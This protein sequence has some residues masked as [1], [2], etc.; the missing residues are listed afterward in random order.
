ML[1][2]ALISG[3]VILS[4]LVATMNIVV[5]A[6]TT[7]TDDT[8]DVVIE[9]EPATGKDYIDIKQ[10]TASRD[11]RKVTLT[12]TV[13]GDIENQGNILFWRLADEEF[14]EEYTSG[15]TEEEITNIFMQLLSE[16]IVQYSFELYTSANIYTI[17]Y[18]KK[19]I[20]ILDGEL[21]S[22]EGTSSVSGGTLTIT[23]NLPTSQENMTEIAAAAEES[24]NSGETFYEDEEGVFGTVDDPL[25]GT[26]DT[27]GDDDDDTGAPG[28]ELITILVAIVIGAILLRKRK[29]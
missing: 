17:V 12:L 13:E 3:A 16:D 7:L 4:F 24:Q 1:K 9:G 23:F 21:N 10:I 25:G 28:F 26:V 2:K 20:V 27:N 8:G 5:A 22:L 18:I 11:Y 15:M 14:F 19:E 6:P 29:S